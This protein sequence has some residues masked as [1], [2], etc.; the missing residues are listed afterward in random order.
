YDKDAVKKVFGE[1]ANR[2]KDRHGGYVRILKRGIRFGD[3]ARLAT[4]Q[5]VDYMPKKEEEK[6]GKD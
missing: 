6:I 1:L 2:F 5:F 4:I 3:G